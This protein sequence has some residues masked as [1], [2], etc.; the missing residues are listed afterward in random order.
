MASAS[1]SQVVLLFAFYSVMGWIC[2]SIWCS[3]GTRRAVNRGFLS[4]PWCPIYGFGALF[5]LLFAYPLKSNPLLTFAICVLT[6]SILEYFTGWLMEALFQTRW[7]DY[8]GRR[9]N[10]KGR[11]CLRNLVLFGLLGLAITYFLQPAA[12]RFINILR[13]ETGRV[14]ASLIFALFLLDL[15]RT[16]A[17]V[18][19][20]RERMENLKAIFE[21]LDQYQHEYAWYDKSD[22]AGSVSRLRVICEGAGISEKNTLILQGIDAVERRLKD[23]LRVMNAFPKMRPQGLITEHEILRQEWL[24]KRKVRSKER[25]CRLHSLLKEL[26][27]DAVIAYK[28]I[29]LTGMVWVFLIGCI[30]GF[31]VETA[32]GLL[33]SGTFE[34][35]Q[36]MLYG[37]FSQ[38]YG[39]GAVIMV[40]ALTPLLSKNSG[41]LFCGSALVGGLYQ[42]VC[43]LIQETFLES[44]SWQYASEPFTLF[45]GR[46]SLLYMFF[47]G[48]LG[49]IFIRRLYPKTINLVRR[50]PIRPKRF[51]TWVAAIAL[52]LNML[53]SA[54]AVDRWSNRM[55]GLEPRNKIEYLLDSRYP[56]EIMEE[57]YPNLKFL[58]QSEAIDEK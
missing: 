18:T 34:S 27:Q 39:F 1:F 29:T 56:N 11:I 12:E 45:G 38:V 6:S 2:E 10:L 14:L 58:R 28:D 57:I 8:S 7:W 48:V 51:F 53:L 16:L 4:G 24:V 36:G 50:L 15:I 33:T 54:F 49:T 19:G 5:I 13:P 30:A 37:P 22:R 20:L 21:E 35:R 47:W 26:R 42:A 46:T 44:V 32:G 41:W 17:S 31:V 40:L 9:F 25:R 43:G 55:L 52:S 23:G 3:V